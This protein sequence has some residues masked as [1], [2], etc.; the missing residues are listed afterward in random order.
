[1]QRTATSR[2][3]KTLME[4]IACIDCAVWD[5]VG[6]ATGR[7]VRELMGGFRD[8]L[9]I[10]SIG[11]YY[12]ENKTLADVGREMEAYRRAGMAGGTIKV[13]GLS[14]QKEAESVKVARG[15]GGP[16]FMLSVDPNP[17]WGAGEA[18]AVA[19]V[20]GPPG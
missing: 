20:G 19:P 5:V 9:P 6:K 7:S 10:I 3:R 15:A 13:G 4:A 2:D 1:F 18:R 14:P 12:M 17:G 16:Q 11:G 8:K